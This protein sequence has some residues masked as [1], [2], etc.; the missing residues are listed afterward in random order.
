MDFSSI[1]KILKK[2]NK[3][4]KQKFRFIV[5]LLLRFGENISEANIKESPERFSSVVKIRRKRLK[6][7]KR[8]DLGSVAKIW[9][10][11]KPSVFCS[12]KSGKTHSDTHP[13][14]V[15]SWSY[16]GT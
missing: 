15:F 8:K 14:R 12:K 13:F 5:V 3:R 4:K 1:A 7:K 9:R 6:R 2:D 11:F 16:S 10:Y